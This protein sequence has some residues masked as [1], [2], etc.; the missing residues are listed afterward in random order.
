MLLGIGLA[1]LVADLGLVGLVLW[2]RYS[3]AHVTLGAGDRQEFKVAQSL[4]FDCRVRIE[5]SHRFTSGHYVRRQVRVEN[6]SGLV[7]EHEFYLESPGTLVETKYDSELVYLSPGTYYV[8]ATGDT[9]VDQSSFS[10]LGWLLVFVLF[11]GL[12][13]SGFALVEYS[14]KPNAFVPDV[15]K[16]FFTSP[17]GFLTASVILA[18]LWLVLAF[19]LGLALMFL[20]DILMLIGLFL[21]LGALALIWEGVKHVGGRVRG[22]ISGAYARQTGE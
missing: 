7:W 14:D 2:E 16:T 11:P 6:G 12:T 19:L 18:V 3:G 22:R 8:S 13:A 10:D 4:F 5:V 15:K 21:V 9:K 20:W 1:L 17:K